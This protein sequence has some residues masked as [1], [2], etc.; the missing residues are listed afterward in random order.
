MYPQIIYYVILGT[1]FAFSIYMF[2]SLLKVKTVNRIRFK[3]NRVK[4]IKQITRKKLENKEMDT[5]FYYSGLNIKGHT[6]RFTRYMIFVFWAAIIILTYVFQSRLSSFQLVLFVVS[7]IV[8]SPKMSFAGIKTP[9]AII[10]SLLT[11]EFRDKKNKEVYMSICQL[12][13]IA[14]INVGDIGSDYILEHL[15]KFTNYTKPVFSK[16]LKMWY[17]YDKEIACDYFA[18]AIDTEEGKNLADIFR[19]LDDISPSEIKAELE[20]YQSSFISKRQT[21]KEKKNE[22]R[23]YILYGFVII[24]AMAVLVNFVMIVLFIDTLLKLNS[25]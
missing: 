1:I 25:F 16:M 8:T 13:N 4:E 2:S 9:F 17:E 5:I 6:Y 11:K 3:R 7:F 21:V 23:G 12:K 18:S 15:I 24:S 14:A 22:N 19:K 20:V 10:T